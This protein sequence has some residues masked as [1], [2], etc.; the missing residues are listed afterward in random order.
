MRHNE[1]QALA[2]FLA[3]V[4]VA[5]HQIPKQGLNEVVVKFRHV[6]QV[7][8]VSEGVKELCVLPPKSNLGVDALVKQKYFWHQ[9][10]VD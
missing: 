5:V 3:Q 10:L 8:G 2:D 1:H 7:E 4:V 9:F 6:E